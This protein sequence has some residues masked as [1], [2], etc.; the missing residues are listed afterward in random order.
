SLLKPQ[1]PPKII[2]WLI[3]FTSGRR[4][5]SLV[6][7]M[8]RGEVSIVDLKKNLEYA[9]TVLESHSYLAPV[10]MNS[11]ISSL[12]LCHQ[13]SVTGWLLPSHG[14][15]SCNCFFLLS[16]EVLLVSPIICHGTMTGGGEEYL[17]P[18]DHR[19]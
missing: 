15:A 13:R 9:T 11:V 5:W 14:K 8:E 4:L 12:T 3:S 2:S 10:K 16:T 1:S 17:R 18:D 7:Q 6:K 19:G